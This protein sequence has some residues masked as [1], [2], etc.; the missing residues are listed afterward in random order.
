M[1]TDDEKQRLTEKFGA[2]NWQL[3]DEAYRMG[4]EAAYERLRNPTAEAL[5]RE[6]NTGVY[7]KDIPAELVV[8]EKINGPDVDAIPWR[9]V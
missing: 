9:P 2:C 8:D 1:L 7:V 5:P 4:M 3:L 6:T